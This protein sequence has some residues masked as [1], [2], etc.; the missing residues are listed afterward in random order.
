MNT[1]YWL[2]IVMTVGGYLLG[3]IPFGV[4]AA[5]WLG[6]ID[7]RTAGSCNIGFTNVLRV[8]GK[9]AGL[10]TLACDA[11]KGW[12]VAWTAFQNIDNE[13]WRL[14]IAGSPIVGHVYSAFLNFRGGKGVATALGAIAGIAP[15]IALSML[16]VWL[17]AA[18]IWQYSSGAA[19]ATFIAFPLIAAGL[20][21]G[22]NFQIFSLLIGGL[23]LFRH[24][25]NLVR[26]WN[27]QE[28][29]IGRR[30]TGAI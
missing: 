25:E 19:V 23:I 5:R 26:I 27:G 4:V 21:M 22:W 15:P 24:K 18:S 17:L 10:V 8:A 13:V 9:K 2:L 1:G 7:P 12:I 3:S 29:R 11:G 6:T 28:P 14:M 20:Q 30:P 16:L